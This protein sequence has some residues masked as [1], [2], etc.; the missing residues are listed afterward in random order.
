MAL[1]AHTLLA[2]AAVTLGSIVSAQFDTSS[3]PAPTTTPSTPE[4]ITN[5]NSLYYIPFSGFTGGDSSPWGVQVQ[6]STPTNGLDPPLVLYEIVVSNS[7]VPD[8]PGGYTGCQQ[9]SLNIV[10]SQGLPVGSPIPLLAEP[11]TTNTLVLGSNSSLEAG[12]RDADDCPNIVVVPTVPFGLNLGREGAW[13]GSVMLGGWFDSNRVASTSWF[14]V[15]ESSTSTILQG[16]QQVVTVTIA[17]VPVS[18]TLD[19]NHDSLVLPSS[20]PC[21]SNITITFAPS[22]DI[23]IPSSL[24]SGSRCSSS[25]SGP[26]TLG[27][28]FFQAAY[29]YVDTA[30]QVFL[31]AANQYNLSVFP[32]E[33]QANAT[34]QVP[35]S[36]TTAAA[37]TSTTKKSAAAT[38]RGRLGRVVFALLVSCVVFL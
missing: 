19:F 22:V 26:A 23:T 20:I 17:S 36:P 2:V 35:A 30:G 3:Q 12:G 13:D 34:L 1:N 32:A 5:T 6:N 27:R 7:T 14:L 21:N 18:A 29:A 4:I 33:F 38:W 25:G 15:P 16:G 10:K 37:P 24:T 9:A 8:A 28:P 11:S 31:T